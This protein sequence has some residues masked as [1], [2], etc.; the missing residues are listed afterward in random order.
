MDDICKIYYAFERE[1]TTKLTMTWNEEVKFTMLRNGMHCEIYYDMECNLK[2][3]M[4]WNCL[5][6]IQVPEFPTF[7][8]GT[9]SL[10]DLCL[11]GSDN[12]LDQVRL[13]IYLY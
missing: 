8:S 11:F 10:A 5:K 12:I 7:G 4:I 13:Y 6:K 1:W 3:T 9:L 2:F